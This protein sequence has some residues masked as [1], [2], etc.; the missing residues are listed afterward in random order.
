M[1]RPK[2]YYTNPKL[3]IQINEQAIKT[4]KQ[5]YK[6]EEKLVRQLYEIDQDRVYVRFGH[7]S[8][9]GYCIYGLQMTRTQTQ[10][11]VTAVRRYEP[12]S[13]IEHEH[14]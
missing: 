8:L 13:K 10:R 14:I 4:A 3:L 6:W 9:T 5:I 12:T 11:L 2:H 1:S 7:K